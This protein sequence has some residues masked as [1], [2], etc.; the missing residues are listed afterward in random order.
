MNL[1]TAIYRIC[2]LSP[3]NCSQYRL[4]VGEIKRYHI[5]WIPVVDQGGVYL[6]AIAVTMLK[7]RKFSF[8]ELLH[9]LRTDIPVVSIDDVDDMPLQ[10]AVVLNTDGKVYG[11]ITAPSILEVMQASMPEM[12][13]DID[14]SLSFIMNL[15][16]GGFSIMDKEGVILCVNHDYERITGLK[17]NNVIG[18]SM[19]ELIEEKV[20]DRSIIPYISKYKKSAT[21]CQIINGKHF[22]TTGYPFFDEEKHLIRV[23]SHVCDV[24]EI[25]HLKEFSEI[26]GK[27]ETNQQTDDF[28]QVWYADTSGIV[29]S[30]KEMQSL[31]AT[32]KKAAHFNST[33]LITGESG[34]G[35]ELIATLL[36]KCSNRSHQPF[37]K[38]NCS[39]IPESLLES[40]L[41]GY[42]KGA[43]TGAGK[44]GK[45]GL[46]EMADKGT[47]FLDEIGDM[48]LEFQSKL[49]RVLQERQFLRVGGVKPISV[50]IR[51]IAATNQN[52]AKMVSQGT[53]RRDLYYRLLVIPMHIPSL[54]ERCEDIPVLIRYF[55]DIY[56]KKF[57][58]RKYINEHVLKMLLAYSWNGNVREL[59]NLV[60]R[61]VV[62]APHDEITAAD[63][64]EY[65]AAAAAG[66]AGSIPL[67]EAK[68]QR[69]AA[70]Y[71]KDIVSDM[72]ADVMLRLYTQLHSWNE[73]AKR[74]GLSRATVYRKA[75]K[76][77]LI[78]R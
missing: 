25:I 78:S 5:V 17:Q 40:E 23:F 73:V 52:L 59:K 65:I 74:L 71:M 10:E 62:L 4:E 32:V 35:K 70:S 43:F 21:I 7:A 9:F 55:L 16:C 76:Y 47:F 49:L 22:L 63:L 29:Y 2:P 61:L 18:K 58:C 28:Q 15:F 14:D 38:V 33:V 39:A 12:K 51:I 53:F 27:N 41:F 19:K 44:D 72:E 13:G 60:E 66:G 37:I 69:L 48:P 54:R 68:D 1:T 67:G 24:S 50:D 77:H 45:P 36:H 64:P 57:N 20:F 8:D 75:K 31:I 11:I 34:T 3:Y 30:S 6:G 46:F 56:N 42:E 26:Q